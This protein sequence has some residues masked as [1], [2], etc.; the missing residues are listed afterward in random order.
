MDDHKR[1]SRR[2]VVRSRLIFCRS[3]RDLNLQSPITDP[4][5]RD[6]PKSLVGKIL[7]H[8]LIAGEYEREGKGE[9]PFHHRGT[10]NTE[11]VTYVNEVSCVFATER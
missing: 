9:K 11:K 2:R 10:E 5:V 8:K 1:R 7:R 4:F 6:I 3:G